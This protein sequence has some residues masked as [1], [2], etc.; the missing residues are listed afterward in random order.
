MHLHR[1]DRL[2]LAIYSGE[3]LM[4]YP[5]RFLAVALML[6]CSTAQPAVYRWLDV[7]GAVNYGAQPPAGATNITLQ[8]VSATPA[9]DTAQIT[10]RDQGNGEVLLEWAPQPDAIGYRVERTG[11]GLPLVSLEAGN[12]PNAMDIAGLAPSYAYRVFA[13]TGAL[14]ERLIGSLAYTPPADVIKRSAAAGGY[15]PKLRTALGTNLEGVA[16]WTSEVPF[17]DVMK[18]SGDWI[19]GDSATWDNAKPLDL[20]A[21]GWIRSLAPG[22]VARKLMLRDIADHYPA[23]QYVVRYKGEGTLKFQFAARVLSSS[24]GQ[25][26]IQVTP[27]A[28]GIYVGIEA[29]NPAN[30]LRDIEVI[31]PGGICEG[32]PFKHAVP[33]DCGTR[34]FL[35]FADYARSI[36]FY[37]VFAERL[38][39]YSVLRF[40]DW[41]KA[42]GSTVTNWSQRT[43]MGNSTWG[44]AYGA[45]A[46]VMVALANRVNAHPWFN[47]PHQADDTYSKNFAQLVKGRL[48]AA[49]GVYVEYSNEV[50]NSM[51]AQYGYSV[52]QGQLQAP[53]IDNT[54]YY[55]LRSR[56]VGQQFK[57]VLGGPR[58]VAVLG[59]QAVNAWTATWGLDYLKARFGAALT[60]ID[61]IAIAP[62]FAVM[63]DPVAASTYTAMSLDAFFNYVSTQVIPQTTSDTAK[64]RAAAGAYGVHLIAYEG[65]QHVV[66]ILSAQ[67]IDALST[68]FDAFNRDPRI[69][70]LYLTYLAGWKQAGGELFVHFN[71]S[72]TFSKWGRWGALEYVSQPR[73][74]APKFDALQTFIETTPVWWPQGTKLK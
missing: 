38:R 16:S 3:E 28:G 36:L 34:R 8:A 24:P 52:A 18:S 61:A 29:T 66:G 45:P 46:E 56:G 27:D 37:P 20:D 53:A 6:A 19:S 33:A 25:T 41:G 54:Q 47:I 32:D 7:N 5:A 64:Y 72:S 15:A 42:N 69:K 65:G 63:P 51:F 60:G 26:L 49:L 17:V 1:R 11:S 44:A 70:D 48:D 43:P 57:A 55:A 71:D 22:Q 40:M 4:N 73:T 31:M 74:A 9:A 23:G 30:Y 68:Q 14:K 39:A 62:Y 58:T 21:N 2:P 13:L 59:G 12:H 67:N 50:W 35:P 10:V